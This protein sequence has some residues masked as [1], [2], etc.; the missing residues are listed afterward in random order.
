MR[1]LL[2]FFLLSAAF[3]LDDGVYRIEARLSGLALKAFDL[4]LC[5]A[6]PDYFVSTHDQSPSDYQLF[7]VASIG[8]GAFRISV[9]ADSRV[10]HADDLGTFKVS[11]VHSDEEDEYTHFTITTA[12][13][14][15]YHVSTVASGRA[16]ELNIEGD[17]GTTDGAGSV[18][19]FTSATPSPRPS[20]RG[21]FRD[22]AWRREDIQIIEDIE[23]GAAFNPATGETE[24]L[25]LDAYLPPESD[26]RELRPAAVLVHGGGFEGNVKNCDRQPEFAMRLVERGYV[27]V[28]IDYR[29]LGD[30]YDM[31]ASDKAETAAVEDARAAVRFLRMV[32]KDYRIDPDRILM[33]GDSAGAITALYHGYVKDAQGEGGSGNPGYRSDVRV[34]IPVSGEVKQQGYCD[35]IH[36]YPANCQID[37]PINHIG[38]FNSSEGKPALFMIHG[39]E[40]YT[41]PYVNGKAVYAAAQAAGIP[42]ALVT[43][44]GAAHVPWDEFYSNVDNM[45]LMMDFLYKHMGLAD[46][47]CPNTNS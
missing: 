46:A 47:E 45:N 31:G 4:P 39:T 5:G 9:V 12:T 42:S 14:G 8:G 30:Y 27:A 28:S 2:A 35:Q 38:D 17:L 32:A 25:H 34:E 26:D 19:K 16:W 1:G 24:V 33:E 13:L 15:G 10:L 29:Q 11:A 44:E 23:F 20:G 37:G 21:C 3:A 43:I 41:V 7:N 6:S 40:D 22:V 36:P 18:F